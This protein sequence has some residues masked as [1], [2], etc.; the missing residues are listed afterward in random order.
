MKAIIYKT[1]GG[2]EILQETDLPIPEVTPGTVLVRLFATSVNPIDWKIASGHYR[3]F[4]RARFPQIPGFDI[5]GEV[6]S[7]GMSV[8]GFVPG[9]RVH[10]RLT[11]SVSSAQYALVEANELVLIPESMDFATAAALPLAGMT[12]LQALRKGGISSGQRVLILGASGGVGHFAVQIAKAAGATVIGVCSN[13]NIAFVESLGADQVI[14]YGA[15]DPYLN[16]PLCDIIFDC[17]GPYSSTWLKH[18][19]DGGRYVSVLPSP[20]LIFASLNPFSRK[21]VIPVMLKS[22]AADLTILN[23]LATSGKLKATVQHFPLD[24]LRNAWELSISGRAVGKI[25]VDIG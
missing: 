9:A 6:V 10:A 22:T 19:K 25:V 18:L 23:D 12:A 1:Y 2:P 21:K 14:D 17:V 5:A 20:A 15:P 11:E 4:M 16:F 13:R 8:T 7:V 24:Q 3:P